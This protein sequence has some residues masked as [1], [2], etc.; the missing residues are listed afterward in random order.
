MRYSNPDDAFKSAL[1]CG[2][3]NRDR[4]DAMYVFNWMY[5]G[6]DSSGSHCFKNRNTRTYIYLPREEQ[7]G[8]R[9]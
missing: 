8:R 2:M 3:F 7:A 5:M 9:A 6:D 1:D 4:A